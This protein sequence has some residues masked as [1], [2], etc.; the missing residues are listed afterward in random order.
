MLSP[1]DAW[2]VLAFVLYCAISGLRARRVA[3]RSLEEYYLAGRTLSG[4]KAGISMAATQFAADT[5]LL[6]TGLVASA[7]IFALWR[8]WIY[9]LAF[10]LMGFLLAR[11]WR[12]AA[13]LTD[14]ELTELRY[15]TRLGIALRA[16]KA[17][18]FGTLFNCT[19]LAMV[20]FAAT[21]VAEPFLRWEEILPAGAFDA[22]ANFVRL[23]GISLTASTDP[24]Q[25]VTRSA[26][27][28]IS[29]LAVLGIT[30]LYSTT[31]GLR[32]VVN[33]DLVQF[34]VA[35]LATLAYAVALVGEVG[36]LAAIPERLAVAY[37]AAAAGQILA[38]TPAEARDAGWIVL[39]TIGIQWFAQINS[40]G[41]GYLAQRTMACRSDADARRAALIFVFAQIVLR[42]LLW[43][44]IALCLLILVPLAPGSDEAARIAAREQSFVEGIAHYL[45]AG[46]RGMMLVG[47]LAALASTLDT[48]LNW[49]GSYWAN[50]VYR[51]VVCE[52]WLDR[53][54][55][56]RALV[57]VARWSN[58]GILV[59]ALVILVNL[60]SIQQAWQTSLLVGAGMGGPLLLRWLW[61]RMTAAAEIAALAISALLVPLLLGGV[62]SEG[63]R[64]LI[65]AL[66]TTA[67]AIGVAA[68]SSS[69][70][71]HAVQEFYS[72]VHPPGFWGPVARS[73]GDPPGSGQSELLRGLWLSGGT[74]AAVFSLLTA[75][76]SWAFGSPAP[77]WFPWR[78]PWIAGLLGVSAALIAALWPGLRA[79][80]RSAASPT[81]SRQVQS[82]RT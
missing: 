36:G 9:A 41:S 67:S 71:S 51:R 10:L 50:D 13:V 24:L 30:L 47:M 52:L 73:I 57:R 4:W 81:E 64:I 5:P 69:T 1:I 77:Y 15:G 70:P 68:L 58:L 61:W 7:G 11:S 26:S 76:G 32:A 46:V 31:G 6:V 65:M 59:L 62:A 22:V 37:G 72:R 63:M 56:E 53:P 33:T 29:L 19:V 42:S 60:R 17:L 16:L 18:Y 74:S 40:D 27:N 8:L 2:L 21:R 38:F 14:A 28:L 49:G 54:A 23:G 44:A 82:G 39:A 48:H 12:R 25:E 35:M 55:G 34:A 66:A 75:L 20:L 43:I 45:P 80:L 78:G 3:S 79:A